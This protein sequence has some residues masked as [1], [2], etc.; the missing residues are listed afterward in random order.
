MR[1]TA[2]FLFSLNKHTRATLHKKYKTHQVR[3]R[4]QCEGGEQGDPLTPVLFDI[5]CARA[6]PG[7]SSQAHAAGWGSNFDFCWTRFALSVTH[8]NRER[9][10]TQWRPLCGNVL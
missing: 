1:L 4:G 6:T 5:V 7:I 10:L 8:S 3:R 9:C 2:K